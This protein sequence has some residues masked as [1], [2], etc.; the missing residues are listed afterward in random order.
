MENRL[1]LENDLLV[2][3]KP[4]LEEKDRNEYLHLKANF[5]G[6][7]LDTAET[8]SDTLDLSI[9]G[10][11]GIIYACGNIQLFCDKAKPLPG[12][13]KVIRELSHN[14]EVKSGFEI[15]SLGEVSITAF[16]MVPY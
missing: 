16:V 6:R 9:V 13:V 5:C 4:V 8:V 14:Y 1:N 2:C 7:V 11:Y 15:V 3:I 12:H 10:P